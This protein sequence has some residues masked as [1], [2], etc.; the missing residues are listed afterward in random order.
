MLLELLKKTTPTGYSTVV[1]LLWLSTKPPAVYFLVGMCC[2]YLYN[3]LLVVLL[4]VIERLQGGFERMVSKERPVD[5]D[6]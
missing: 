2:G 5:A 4:D 6:L 3:R 1:M